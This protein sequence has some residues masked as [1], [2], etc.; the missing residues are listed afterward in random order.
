MPIVVSLPFKGYGIQYDRGNQ[1]FTNPLIFNKLSNEGSS[2]F[3]LT[4]RYERGVTLSGSTTYGY[5]G[6]YIFNGGSQLRR[7]Q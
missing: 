2:Y 1:V 3:S 6:K 4:E 5:A 7:F